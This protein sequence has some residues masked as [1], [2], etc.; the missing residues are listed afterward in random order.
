MRPILI[1]LVI[2]L[3]L[4][5][6]LSCGRKPHPRTAMHTSEPPDPPPVHAQSTVA[7]YDYRVVRAFPHDRKAFTQG[8]VYANGFFYEGTGLNGESTIRQVEIETGRVVRS[9]TLPEEHFGEGIA[10]HD[11]RLVQ[12]TYTSRTGFIYSADTFDSLGTFGYDTEGWG[13][14]SDGRRFIMSDGSP[15]LRVMEPDSL[16]V[17][18]TIEVTDRGKPVPGLNELEFVQGEIFA[19]VWPTFLIARIDPQTGRVLGW[20]DLRGILPMEEL[21]NVDVMNGIAYDTLERR[22]FVT[23]KLWPV[24]FEIELI[25]RE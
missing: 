2:A 3:A 15:K 20:I 1:G 13:I 22:L 9:R 12:L 7:I 4:I 6:L 23:G 14:T 21:T 25:P 8:L 19:N 11:N 16:R 18:G 17:T 10:M 24:V 5:I